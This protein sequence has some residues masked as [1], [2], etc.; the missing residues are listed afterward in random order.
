MQEQIDLYEVRLRRLEQ[1]MTAMVE[2]QSSI[3]QVLQ[4]HTARM[5]RLEELLTIMHDD[6]AF[7]K[8]YLQRKE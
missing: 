2:G 8:N 5:A 3:G 1:M 6:L 4:D 7:I